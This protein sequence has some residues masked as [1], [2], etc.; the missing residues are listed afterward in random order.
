[1]VLSGV[2]LSGL[3][4]IAGDAAEWSLQPYLAITGEYD[5]NIRLTPESQ[6]EAWGVTL[7]PDLSLNYLT[8]ILRARAHA[9]L[10]I[11]RYDDDSLDSD[12]QLYEFLARYRSSELTTW[13]LRAAYQLES[14]LRRTSVDEAADVIVPP[15]EGLPVAD[16]LNPETSTDVGLVEREVERST[17]TFA[18]AWTRRLTERFTLGLRYRYRDVSYD[19]AEDTGLT[20]SQRHS[21]VTSLAYLLTERD[22]LIGEVSYERTRYETDPE[23]RTFEQWELTAG[24]RHLFSETL[25]GRFDAGF[26][27][28]S[29]KQGDLDEDDTGYVARASLDKRGERTV[30]SGRVEHEVL[31]RSTG[32]LVQTDRL[33]LFVD[34]RLSERWRATLLGEIFQEEGLR[35]ESGVRDRFQYEIS[36]ALRWLWTPELSLELTYRRL[37]QEIDDDDGD[38]DAT[39]NAVYLTVD[40]IWPKIVLPW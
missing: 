20:D 26:R 10:D 40:Y 2:L 24:I 39:S 9:A 35:E 13:S 11:V 4:P 33:A 31:P 34:H 29:A 19:D 16:P 30:W 12:E 18:P 22:Q 8:E 28:T 14:V 17:T 23:E 25:T 36:P 7:S 15:E 6:D 1:V 5:D 3:A 37:Y 27:S 32:V 38:E 21:G